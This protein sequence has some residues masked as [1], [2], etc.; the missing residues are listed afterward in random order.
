MKLQ[1]LFTMEGKC[2]RQKD[3]TKTHLSMKL[4]VF[5]VFSCIFYLYNVDG[6]MSKDNNYM[7]GIN[8]GSN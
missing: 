2:T 7:K 3:K 4:A 6:N 5:Q 8:L 1:M